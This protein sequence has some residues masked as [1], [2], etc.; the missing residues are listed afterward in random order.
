MKRDLILYSS[1]AILCSLG[2]IGCLVV[3]FIYIRAKLLRT[4]PFKLVFWLN[5]SNLFKSLL[6]LVPVEAEHIGNNICKVNAYIF[7]SFTLSG[8]LWTFVIANKM[9]NSIVLNQRNLEA[10]Y[11]LYIINIFLISFVVCVIP[12][13]FDAY[14]PNSFNCSFI[15]GVEGDYFRF[16]LYYTPAS[17]ITVYC[18]FV[19]SKVIR[20]I[21]EVREKMSTD[22]SRLIYF[23]LILIICVTPMCIFRIFQI[24]GLYNFYVYTIL[25]CLWCLQSLLDALAYAFTPPVI[26]YIKYVWNNNSHSNINESDLFSIIS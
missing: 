1:Q 24:F 23:P 20:R 26:K 8:L 18:I 2:A 14:G 11:I 25:S 7:Y 19:Y 15:M 6:L 4:Y 12:F 13:I 5:L 16:F 17:V 21:K 9:Y 10:N 22:L 3:I